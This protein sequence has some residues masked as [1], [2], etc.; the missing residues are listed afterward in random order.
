MFPMSLAESEQ[1]ADF[2]VGDVVDEGADRPGFYFVVNDMT[3]RRMVAYRIEMEEGWRKGKRE[4]R[5]IV[6][7]KGRER[8]RGK[9]KPYNQ[10]HCHISPGL[11][12]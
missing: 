4:G 8:R 10:L 3:G 9:S 5:G 11:T 2:P 12:H 1:G 6:R 7:R